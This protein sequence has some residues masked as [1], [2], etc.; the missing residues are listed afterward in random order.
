M[1]HLRLQFGYNYVFK[2]VPKTPVVVPA[3][4]AVVAIA[5]DPTATPPV[6]AVPAV[7]AGSERITFFVS[8]TTCLKLI[9]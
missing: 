4:P 7:A 8:I 1:N 2:L 3:I 5:A 9:Q 6:L